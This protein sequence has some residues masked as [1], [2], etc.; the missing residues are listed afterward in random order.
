MPWTG[1]F[2]VAGLS[3]ACLEGDQ[4]TV[5]RSCVDVGNDTGVLRCTV[6][7]GGKC[8]LAKQKPATLARVP[9]QRGER[10]GMGVSSTSSPQVR[11]SHYGFA[12]LRRSFLPDPALAQALLVPVGHSDPQW[13]ERPSPLVMRQPS[14]GLAV[15]KTW[16]SF[17]FSSQYQF[18]SFLSCSI[19]SS[20]IP[21]SG[22][23]RKR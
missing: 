17:L 23:P 12:N 5:N 3:L 11:Q 2:S 21:S 16:L 9:W 20:C 15:R 4:R 18:G 13:S 10:S 22:L 8:H 7:R 6:R 1:R 19:N 14:S